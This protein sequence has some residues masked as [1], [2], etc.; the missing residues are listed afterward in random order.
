M[1]RFTRGL[2]DKT[3]AYFAFGA[4]VGLLILAILRTLS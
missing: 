1:S 2:I 3:V 4:I